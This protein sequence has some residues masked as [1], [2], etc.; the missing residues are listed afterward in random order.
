MDNNAV[1]FERAVHEMDVD[2]L[3]HAL[4]D[5]TMVIAHLVVLA[6]GHVRI[7]KSDIPDVSGGWV[8][9]RD[10][11]DGTLTLHYCATP[12]D[13]DAVTA[14]AVASRSPVN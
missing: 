10:D 13:V 9:V 5:M 14:A 6:G 8:A 4:Y 12:A 3:R 1:T 2:E 7:V 11:G